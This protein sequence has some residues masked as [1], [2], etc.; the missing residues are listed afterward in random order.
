MGVLPDLVAFVPSMITQVVNGD[1]MTKV[2]ENTVTADLPAISWE[3]YKISHSLIWTFFLFLA[4]W[5]SLE[6][7]LRRLD[8]G[9][10]LPAGKW[11][12]TSMSPR[13]AATF[14]IIPWVF[15]IFLD[16]PTHTIKFFPTP[17]LMPFSDFMVD[18][19]G[20]STWWV[21]GLNAVAFTLVW[22]LIR[23]NDAQRTAAIASTA[24]RA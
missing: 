2:D 11:L 16:I 24:P 14:L 3:L 12:Q 19:V 15:H 10:Q 4:I 13:T 7:R 9:D 1:V 21:W 18:G 23:K 5:G 17:F 8:S 20:W 22:W 6:M